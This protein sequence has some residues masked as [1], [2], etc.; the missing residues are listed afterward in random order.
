MEEMVHLEN[1]AFFWQKIDALMVS[2]DF[3]LKREIGGVHPDYQNLV[4]PVKYGYL[5]DPDV[6]EKVKRIGVF[7]GTK[8]NKTIDAIVV[9]ADILVKELDV[10]LLSGCNDDEIMKILEFLNQT[11]F[12]KTILVRRS[13]EVPLWTNVE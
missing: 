10:K 2:L 11:A 3:Q 7:V 9:C 12:Q 4:Y 5:I 8:S 6:D 1:N 13:R